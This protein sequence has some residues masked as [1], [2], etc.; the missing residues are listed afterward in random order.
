MKNGSGD[1]YT[2][3]LNLGT[4]WGVWSASHSGRFTTSGKGSWCPLSRRLGG[5]YS[6]SGPGGEEN[7]STPAGNWTLIVELLTQSLYLLSYPDT[8]KQNV[9]SKLMEPESSSQ[10]QSLPVDTDE[11]QLESV[12]ATFQEQKTNL[13]IDTDQSQ[14]DSLCHYN[15]SY[16]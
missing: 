8:E 13:P 6:S 15:V 16:L 10:E 1:T 4:G 7:L 3:I 5:L 14:L 11:S 9:M 2:L 12:I